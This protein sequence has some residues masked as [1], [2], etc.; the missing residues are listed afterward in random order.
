[1]KE[2]K[3]VNGYDGND[4]IELGRFENESDAYDS[5]LRELGWLLVEIEK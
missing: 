5:A 2:Y 1:M 3:L 4:E